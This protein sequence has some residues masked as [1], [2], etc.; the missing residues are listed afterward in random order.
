MEYHSTDISRILQKIS[1][2]QKGLPL[3][4]RTTRRQARRND[5]GVPVNQFFAAAFLSDAGRRKESVPYE[6][7]FIS[8]NNSM[9]LSNFSKSS[10]VPL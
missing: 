2:R 9:I 8:V 7:L 1:P 6:A 10:F 4:K 3:P 5:T